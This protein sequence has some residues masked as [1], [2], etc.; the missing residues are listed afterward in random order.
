M[1]CLTTRPRIALRLIVIAGFALCGVDVDAAEADSAP[2]D[3]VIE[4]QPGESGAAKRDAPIATPPDATES[5]RTP[6]ISESRP[7]PLQEVAVTGS[8]LT[9]AEAQ[10]SQDVRIYDRPRI[11]RSGQSTVTDFLNTLPEVSLNSMEST[12]LATTV[13]LRGAVRGSVL[14]LINGRRSQA[15]TGGAA[16]N[17]F[18]DL[19]M[20]PLSMVERI[21][22]LPTGSSAVYGGDAL[23]GVVNIILRSNFTGAEANG[24]YK[25]ARNTDEK[26]FSVGGGWKVDDLSMSIMASYSHRSSLNGKDR[27]ITANPDM[28]RFGGPNLGTAPFGAPATVFSTSGN[29]PGLNSS[30]AAVPRGSSG[31]GMA[32]SD[33]AATAGAQNTGSFTSYSDAIADSP[34]KGLLFNAN[35]RLGSTVEL[36]AELLAS[37]Y[38]LNSAFTPPFL[39]LTTVPASNA[40]N[41]FGVNVRVSGVVQGA[42]QFGRQTFEEEFVRPLVGGRGKVHEWEWEVTALTSRDMGSSALYG[43]SPNTTAL[44]AA[45]ASSNPRTALNPFVDGPMG[46]PALLASI[47]SNAGIV[48][49]FEATSNIVNGFVRGPLLKLP[50]GPLNAVLGTEYEKSNFE[51]GFEASR[52]NKALFAELRVPLLAGTDDAGAKREVLAV[53]GGARYDKYGDFGSKATWQTGVELRPVERLLLRGTH[54]TAFKPPTLYNLAVPPSVGA[55][56]VSDPR[57]NGATVVATGAFG[58]NPLL[59]P[60]TGTSSTLGAVWSPPQ[61]RGLNASLTWWQLRI[62]NA[63][64]LPNPQFIV[65]NE[66]LYPGR[67]TRG[68]NGEITS[69]N[70]SYVNFGTMRQEG[71]DAALDWTI[72]TSVGQFTPAIAATYMTKYEGSS[73]PGAPSVDR[74][75]RAN[76]DLNFAPQWKGIASL[77]WNPG[78]AFNLW[79]A[80]RYIGRYTDF[81]P[82]RTIG[83]VWYLDATLQVALEPALNLDKGKLGGLKL[84][85]SGT[86]LTDKLPPYS[87]YFRG[88]DVSNY[89]L[90]G[91][92]IFVRLQLQL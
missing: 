15:V 91:R 12:N 43:Q 31:V 39:Q 85:V 87:T 58:G 92:T 79:V 8:R 71:I 48:T 9:P 17:G 53:Q 83:D 70:Y 59:D 21:E 1:F 6:R 10:S 52:S 55:I 44:N 82:P 4:R 33:F 76:N 45:L 16:N 34:R 42:E 2:A 74:L 5:P 63:I 28:R 78:R 19:N 68:S 25:W 72:G 23:A 41:P 47:Y 32:P 57:Q 37:E 56:S 81:T 40:F 65:D 26:L 24:G 88:Y 18:F 20:I 3:P 14:V 66:N 90:V 22:V 64:S 36:F 7:V 29:L 67:V 54:A 61:A 84:L 11:E 86:N 13:R 50:A 51:R 30:F 75:S 77:G 73:T 60:T 46:S 38:R 69:I 62:D 49:N 80:G 27:D 89:D 35:Y